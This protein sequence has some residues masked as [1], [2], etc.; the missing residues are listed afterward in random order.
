MI[1]A[2]LLVAQYTGA[3]DAS[4]NARVA[5]RSQ[6]PAPIVKT[7][8]GTVGTDVIAMDVAVSP[9][10]RLRLN[11]HFWDFTVAYTPTFTAADLE[12][13]YAPQLL[14][15][16]SVSLA[17]HHRFV[18][19]SLTESG[20]YGSINTGILYAYGQ[21][22]PNGNTTTGTGTGT[23]MGQ[24]GQTTGPTSPTSPATQQGCNAAGSSGASS[25]ANAGCFAN[26]TYGASSTT[27]SLL[28]QT[29][30]HDNL[31]LSA[32][33]S[34]GGALT[35]SGKQSIAE[36]YGPMASASFSEFPS[37]AD[38]VGVLV[39][40]QDTTTSGPCP[41]PPNV[42]ANAT[43]PPLN[44]CVS[45]SPLYSLQAVGHHFFTAATSLTLNTGAGVAI[46]DTLYLHE[47]IIEPVFLATYTQQL[48]VRGTSL[49]S[50]SLG[51]VPTVD[52]RTGAPV[53]RGTAMV[54]YSDLIGPRRV[55]TL[56]GTF[57]QSL[58]LP[59]ADPNSLTYLSGAIDI[60]SK[61]DPLFD[62]TYGI[63]S[64]WQGQAGYGSLVSAIGY[65]GITARA[66]KARF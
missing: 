45:Q 24:G 41:V 23:G 51:L 19:F 59:V 6:V 60:T 17:W 7:T 37:R 9:I 20:S 53:N 65:V 50:A 56:T 18:R 34:F 4:A 28:V 25:A 42:S 16:G 63:Q 48:K 3:L 15:N 38:S 26:V 66:P 12:I 61:L 46:A 2:A 11:D 62:L 1:V 64:V 40:A 30:R 55:L 8:S 54:T 10:V 21:Q 32:G 58:P 31:G 27:G 44:T 14:H 43:L 36:Q 49:G 5:L 22:N 52:I 47:V 35:E 29:G 13:G 39:T 57:L 33:Y